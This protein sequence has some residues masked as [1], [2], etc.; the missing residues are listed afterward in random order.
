MMSK[1]IGYFDNSPLTGI[2]SSSW[3]PIDKDGLDKDTYVEFPEEE[4]LT[5]PFKATFEW[6]N[7]PEFQEDYKR[8]QRRNKIAEYLTKWMKRIPIVGYYVASFWYLLIAEGFYQTLKP[9][10]GGITFSFLNDGCGVSIW[11]TWKQVTD[12]YGDFSG[13]Y[14]T[15]APKNKAQAL[16]WEEKWYQERIDGI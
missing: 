12:P 1:R 13:I 6:M 5:G 11:H 15:G 3:A 14:T 10:Y 16:E 4:G 9:R 8:Y 7:S 2:R